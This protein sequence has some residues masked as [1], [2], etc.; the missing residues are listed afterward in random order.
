M[1]ARP[2]TEGVTDIALVPFWGVDQNIITQFGNV[3]QAN[4]EKNEAYTPLPVDMTN[5]PEDV[6]EGGFPPYICPSPSLIKESPYAITGELTRNEDEDLYHLRLY[7]WEM[8]SSRLLCSDELAAGDR[9]QCETVLPSLLEWM[10]SWTAK[11][12][13]ETL[14]AAVPEENWLYLGLRLGPSLRIYS[15]PEEAPILEKEVTHYFNI[16]AA[17]Q[18]AFEFLP[19]L[20][21]QAELV[22][23][24]DYAPFSA[25]N[26]V[27]QEFKT[28]PMSSASLMFPLLLKYTF[29]KNSLF[30]SALGGLYF[31]L[32]LGEME[33][34]IFG[35]NFEY[36]VD[37][38][39][40]YTLGIDLGMKMGPGFLFLDLRWAADLG[41]TVIK[42]TGQTLYKRSMVSLCVGYQLGFFAKN[43]K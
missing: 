11:P 40:G 12:G 22:F 21:V 9:Q 7:L 16:S 38:P 39:V 5:L 17:F 42:D 8:E 2:F 32:P 6:P 34:D 33:N 43:R 10:L 20:G 30:A 14:A 15:R 13:K 19:F 4:L 25:Y 29:R 18:A 26:N 3:L 41:T 27:S 36:S 37:P 1:D 35:G 28:D 31:T 24:T 23:T